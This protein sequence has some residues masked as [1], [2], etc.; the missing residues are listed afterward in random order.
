MSTMRNSDCEMKL[1]IFFH[2]SS[3]L[4]VLAISLFVVILKQLPK[5][6]IEKLKLMRLHRSERIS[7]Q[8][9]SVL[10]ISQGGAVL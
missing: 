4:I 10:K 6:E 9:R 7:L 5:I 3:L 1:A 2:L 8:L